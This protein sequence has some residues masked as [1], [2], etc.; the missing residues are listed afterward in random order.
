MKQLLRPLVL[1]CILLPLAGTLQ[2]QIK[3]KIGPRVGFSTNSIDGDDL[4]IL[5]PVTRDSVL[6]KADNAN[7]GFRFGLFTRLEFATF[8]I[9][10][11]VLLKTVNNEYRK[12]D[13]LTGLAEV[14]DE[15]FL[16]VDVPVLVG[17]KLGPLR[18]QGGPLASILLSKDSELTDKDTLSRSFDDAEWAIQLGAGIDLWKLA[19]DLNYQINLQESTDG[20]SVDGQSYQL[21]GDN[22]QLVLSVALLLN[23]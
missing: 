22:T 3:L 18:L 4:N 15:S 13:I 9:Q 19:I 23:N 1:L 8:Y 6:L 11:E 17:F 2:A 16:Y 10:P 7:L 14:R 5:D 21:D 20:I 12:E